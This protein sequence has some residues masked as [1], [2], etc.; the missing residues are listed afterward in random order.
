MEDKLDNWDN[1]AI[2]MNYCDNYG[3][4]DL[5]TDEDVRKLQELEFEDATMRVILEH[6]NDCSSTKNSV[7]TLLSTLGLY[8]I[9]Q[10]KS[11]L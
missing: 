3:H 2:I 8:I 1:I 6:I 10:M 11:K 7:E 5:A 4:F 9:Y